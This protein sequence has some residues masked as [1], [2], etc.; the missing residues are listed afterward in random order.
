MKPKFKAKYE[1]NS[2]S[3]YRKDLVA[4]VLKK[5][6]GNDISITIE[7]W[8]S[9]RTLQQNAYIHGVIF[10]M[11]AEKIG[12]TLPEAK[13]HVKMEIGFYERIGE[14]GGEQYIALKETSKLSKTDFGLFIDVARKWAKDTLG[15]TIPLPDETDLDELYFYDN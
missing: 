10:K 7:K 13:K 12:F 6:E 3:F 5:L 8:S 11:V 15:I 14:Y 4:E 9:I 2:L 1:N